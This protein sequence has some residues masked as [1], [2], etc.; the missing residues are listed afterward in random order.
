MR[1]CPWTIPV[2]TGPVV[3]L[4]GLH[5][6]YADPAVWEHFPSGRHTDRARTAAMIAREGAGWAGHGLGSWVVR[7]AA[8]PDGAVL[9]LAGCRWH[10]GPGWN[11]GYRF[12]RSAWGRG[13]AGEAVTAALAAAGQVAPGLPVV[14]YLLEH[15]TGSRRTAERAGLQLAWRGRDVGNPDPQA[16]RLVYADRPVSAAVLTAFTDH[17]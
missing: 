15:N 6:V 12:T 14:A 1:R 10:D 16:V 9:G 5:A 4:P 17:P 8:D 3:A 13:L 11:L 2:L 7:S